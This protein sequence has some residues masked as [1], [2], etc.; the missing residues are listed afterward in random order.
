MIVQSLRVF[1]LFTQPEPE[2]EP[3]SFVQNG[4]GMPPPLFF[5]KLV[6]FAPNFLSLSRNREK[7]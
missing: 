7:S 5:K 6:I 1:F 2:P 4:Y 3:L